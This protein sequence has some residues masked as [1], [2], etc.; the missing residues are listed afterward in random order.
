MLLNKVIEKDNT[1]LDCG[2]KKPKLLIEVIIGYMYK[3]LK[4]KL[5]TSCF[6]N[7]F[8]AIR[9]GD[10]FDFNISKTKQIDY[11]VVYNMGVIDKTTNIKRDD[12]DYIGLVKS[13][14]SLKEFYKKCYSKFGEITDSDLQDVY[15]EKATI[16]E[17][18]LRMNLNNKRKVKDRITLETVINE[19][20]IIENLNNLEIEILHKGRRFLNYLKR[21]E[22][23]KSNWAI[24]SSEFENAFSLLK[25]KKLTII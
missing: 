20:S 14:E 16:F 8:A 19:I 6:K 9:Y 13:S 3:V 17:L 5:D 25:E 1:N 4:N 12:S 23:L 10:Y 24:V 15:F 11:I 21:P 2:Y 7:E 22:K 18:S